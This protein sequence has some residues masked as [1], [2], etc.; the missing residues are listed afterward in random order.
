[1]KINER[2][3]CL[4]EQYLFEEVKRRTK[5]LSSLLHLGIGDV[6]LPLFDSV[7]NK[8]K[9][10]AEE[11]GNLEGFQGYPPPYGYPFLKEK[12]VEYYRSFGAEIEEDDVFISSGSKEELGDILEL[13]ARGSTALI[14]NPAYPVYEEVN[15]LYGNNVLYAYGNQEN[16]FLPLPNGEKVDLI[17]LCS[18]NNPTGA[19]YTREQLSVW[20]E[21]ARR[22]D[23]VII[24]DNAYERFNPSGVRSLFQIEGVD[25]GIEI[26]SFS[27]M[28]GFTGVRLGWTIVPKKCKEGVL[29]TL[30]KRRQS[31]RKNGVSYFS[32]KAG[33]GVFTKEGQREGEKRIAYY[34]KNGELL[35]NTLSK[36]GVWHTRGGG[37]VWA[38]CPKGMD[39]WGFFDFLLQKGKIVC[40]P[41]VG[42]GDGGEGFV[43]FSTLALQETVEKGCAV[44][45]KIL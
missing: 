43:R 27:K 1:M 9:E 29:H 24:F 20:V 18:P 35:S 42:F 44:L 14:P 31:T 21:Y 10:G 13:F 16:H 26:G 39:S 11:Q 6:R 45:E 41:G 34:Q 36:L 28:A 33:L 7:V 2:F 4:K 23:A 5:G 25:C 37:Y 22:T 38:Q 3:A 40:T 15:R 8:V 19:T 17:Y 12:I 32:Q 30:W